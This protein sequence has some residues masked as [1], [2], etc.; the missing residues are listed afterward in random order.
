MII[1][2]VIAIV[3]NRRI[4]IIQ[5]PFRHTHAHTILYTW[6]R[7]DNWTGW[8]TVSCLHDRKNVP[9]FIRTDAEARRRRRHRAN[10]RK[11]LP[12][13]T[14]YYMIIIICS[15]LFCIPL[16][17]TT[18][19]YAILCTMQDVTII[20]CVFQNAWKLYQNRL[21]GAG[22]VE[23]TVFKEMTNTDN[24]TWC[25]APLS[26]YIYQIRS[27][28]TLYYITLPFKSHNIV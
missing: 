3:V 11:C 16:H 26:P 4:H 13:Y 28:F 27:R 14:C 2:I 24:E 6:E 25:E 10:H 19:R 22:V 15:L 17:S 5:N 18:T 23:V 20:I 21:V 12:C 1:I 8:K 7:H 9:P